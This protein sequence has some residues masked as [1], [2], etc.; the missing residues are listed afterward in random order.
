MR[1]LLVNNGGTG[2]SQF[3]MGEKRFPIGLGYLSAML[4]RGGH[5]TRLVDRFADHDAW[6]EDLREVDFV[7]VYAS[8]PCFDDALRIL[9]LLEGYEGPIAFGGPHTA[10]FPNTVPPRVNYVV[11]GEAE[12]L[13]NDLV[14]GRFPDGCL[15]RPQRRLR[16]VSGSAPRLPLDHAVQQRHPAHLPDEYVAKLP[17]PVH[18]LH[19]AGHLGTPVD[20]SEPRA[21]GR[22]HPIPEANL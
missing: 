13:I 19:G 3:S 9:D 11:Q 12:C 14:E 6:V 18:V 2:S 5:T 10:A 8:T 4:K 17:L 22:R 20:Q 7:A 16:P 1:V 15:I 21:G